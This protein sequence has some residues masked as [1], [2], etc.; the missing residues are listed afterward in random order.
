MGCMNSCPICHQQ[1]DLGDLCQRC[2]HAKMV[3]WFGDPAKPSETERLRARVAELEA[4]LRRA[5]DHCR[6]YTPNRCPDG[7]SGDFD[8]PGDG[9]MDAPDGPC[10]EC[11]YRFFL[12]TPT[13]G[14][15]NG[16]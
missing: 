5:A 4:A 8:C 6:R 2:K 13:P 14:G 11:F 7:G 1:S 12:T 15:D 10:N 16:V 3:E 9:V